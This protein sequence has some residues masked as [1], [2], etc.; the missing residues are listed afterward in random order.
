MKRKLTDD[1][2]TAA[3]YGVMATLYSIAEFTE[4][5]K[6]LY[7]HRAMSL[8]EKLWDNV[9]EEIFQAHAELLNRHREEVSLE[10][11]KREQY[12]KRAAN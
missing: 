1:E 5:V 4:E 6:I 12:L 2:K 7:S 11:A 8:M 3:V 9:P 10:R